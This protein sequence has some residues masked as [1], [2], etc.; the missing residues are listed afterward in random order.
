MGAKNKG[1]SF[2]REVCKLLSLWWSGNRHDNIFWRSQSSGGRATQRAGKNLKTKGQ[3]GDIAA[4]GE[5]GIKLIDL[6][7]IELK[8]GYNESS[9]IDL[10]DKPESSAEHP[11]EE[12][13]RKLEES[14]HHSGS[15]SWWLIHK[16]D[17][18]VPMI[19]IPASAISVLREE[20]MLCDRLSARVNCTCR[21]RGPEDEVNRL[22]VVGMALDEWLKV[23]DPQELISF[24]GIL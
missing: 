23:L 7:M 3:H 15:L 19:Y 11:F 14:L 22:H 13:F 17:R 9:L 18:R 10:L 12:W 8:R 21:I 2:E 16:K 1:N 24:S 4:D 6:F 20:G 5:A